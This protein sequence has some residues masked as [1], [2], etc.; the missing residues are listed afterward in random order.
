MIFTALILRGIDMTTFDIRDWVRVPGSAR[1]FKNQKTGVEVSRHQFDKMRFGLTHRQKAKKAF[2]ADPKTAVLRPAKGR[3]SALKAPTDLKEAIATARLDK[4][5]EAK[6]IK[7]EEKTLKALNK[8]IESALNKKVPE[9]KI[10]KQ[11]LKT[12]HMGVRKPFKDYQDFLRLLNDAR[13]LGVIFSYSLGWRGVSERPESAGEYLDVSV[14]TQQH[15]SKTISEDDFNTEFQVS[16][17][18]KS[19][20]SFKNFFMHFAFK[21]EYAQERI[22]KSKDPKIKKKYAYL[23][24][25]QNTLF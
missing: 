15:I 3:K 17:L 2:L 18:E 19:Y 22:K 16:F 23:F 10:T 5:E 1:R 7:E 4:K 20:M 25:S 11:S 12:G 14:F 8:K 21:K 13:K 24:Q 9:S 6:R